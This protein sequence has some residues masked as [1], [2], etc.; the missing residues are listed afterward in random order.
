[1]CEYGF[2]WK[3]QKLI[4]V[5][6]EPVLKDFSR[7]FMAARIDC[8]M[9]NIHNRQRKRNPS[10]FNADILHLIQ[11]Y[12][13][14]ESSFQQESNYVYYIQTKCCKPLAILITSSFIQNENSFRLFLS[15]HIL[16][17]YYQIFF[18]SPWLFPVWKWTIIAAP[19]LMK[20]LSRIKAS[21]FCGQ[22][23]KQQINHYLTLHFLFCAWSI[24]LQEL[25]CLYPSNYAGD[26]YDRS[27]THQQQA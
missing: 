6:G 17:A 21:L 9:I 3:C 13:Y 14:E 26:L 4:L 7:V 19:V 15:F 8:S 2:G 10:H 22:S 27:E 18:W 1:M 25:R 23:P 12:C 5:I 16:C 11:I 24:G 20:L